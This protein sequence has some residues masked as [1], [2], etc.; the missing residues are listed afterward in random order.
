M[1]EVPNRFCH[2]RKWGDGSMGQ[3]QSMGYPAKGDVYSTYRKMTVDESRRI[4]EM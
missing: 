2:G 1:D 3:N 4:A